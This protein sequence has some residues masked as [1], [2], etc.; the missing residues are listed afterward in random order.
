VYSS[1]GANSDI[2]VADSCQCSCASVAGSWRT[3]IIAT[4]SAIWA[5]VEVF[6]M[7]DDETARKEVSEGQ[8]WLKKL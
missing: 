7:A 3:V 4:N 6:M 8:R 2:V 5:T 1:C